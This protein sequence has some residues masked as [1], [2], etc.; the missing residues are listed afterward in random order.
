MQSPVPGNGSTANVTAAAGAVTKKADTGS[1]AGSAVRPPVDTATTAAVNDRITA[2]PVHPA[3]GAGSATSPEAAWCDW[4]PWLFAID[5]QRPWSNR[6]P[7]PPL[8]VSTD[9]H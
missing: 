4:W 2:T 6:T 1:A 3:N 5:P 7:L 8:S 9:T